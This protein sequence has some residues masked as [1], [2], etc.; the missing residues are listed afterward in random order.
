MFRLFKDRNFFTF[1]I[2]EF[3]SVVGDHISLIAFPFLVLQMTGSPALTAF[4]LAAQGIP[5]GILMLVG[6][7]LVD[8]Y[9]P[10]MV[11]I[12]SNLCRCLLVMGLA[13]LIAIDAA[14]LPLI[15]ACAVLFGIAD[16]FFYP[17]NSSMVPTVVAK[18]DLKEGNAIVQGSTWVGVI[19]GPAIAGFIIAGSV[20]TLGHDAGLEAATYQSSRDGF[21][22]AFFI[23][24]LTFAFS[25][26]TL[27]F[28]KA[29]KLNSE[30]DAEGDILAKTS[31]F[32]EVK[33][34]IKWVWSV[35]AIR[36]GF[37]GVAIIEFFFQTPIFVGLPALVKERFL[38]PTYVYGLI[39]TAYGTG[40]LI[41]AI[42][43]GYA[44]GP[45]PENLIRIMFIFYMGTGAS[46]ALIVLYE[47]YW[48]AMLLFLV[49]GCADSFMWVHF[50][51]LIQKITPEK[52]L[53]RVMSVLMFMAVGLVPIASII[54]GIAFEINLKLS[55][56]TASLIIVTS[57]ILAAIHP[58]SRRISP[59]PVLQPQKEP[60]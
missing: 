11:M 58:D 32:S 13:Y 24:G 4:V 16:A 43:G 38:E 18:D 31:M 44:K 52:L 26:I 22:R 8:R 30:D 59:A 36:L 5:R 41:G 17:A 40:A 42:T 29:R 35:P 20:T 48:W 10:R 12:L 51:T 46:I 45:K 6:G 54:M 2:G 39:V 15:F 27:L 53:G 37:I 50:T 55:L 7:A 21:A 3:V 28:V 47:P 14:T 23:D 19:I 56:I 49:F 57:C 1:W 9:S 33:E 34:A 25:F 60:A